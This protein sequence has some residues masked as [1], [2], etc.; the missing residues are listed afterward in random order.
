MIYV[1]NGAHRPFQ[2]YVG[3]GRGPLWLH[4]EA[5]F[6]TDDDEYHHKALG[7]LRRVYDKGWLGRSDPGP[8]FFDLFIAERPGS[9]EGP[10]CEWTMPTDLVW[11][12]ACQL[13]L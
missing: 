3:W 6:M 9:S 7:V 13:C 4:G 2:N 1:P 11:S 8:L 10:P 12:G 5:S